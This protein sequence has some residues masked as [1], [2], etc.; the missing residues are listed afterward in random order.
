VHLTHLFNH[1]LRIGQFP[2]AWKEAKIVTL[3]KTIKDPKIPQNL[4][5]MSFLSNTS[6]LFEKLI[7][8]TI[9]KHTEDRSLLNA[10]HFGF[11]ADQSTTLQ[12][13]R[14]A[15]QVT[16]NFSINM[17]T[18]AVFLDIEKAFDIT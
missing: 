16:L 14:L 18:A 10:S 6:K 17:S 9:Q 11:R 7:L 5:P 13:M 3:P 4:C 2:I 8:R 12:C 15:E 1:C